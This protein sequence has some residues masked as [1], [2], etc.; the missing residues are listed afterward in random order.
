MPLTAE[1]AL[2]QGAMEVAEFVLALLALDRLVQEIN[3]YVNGEDTTASLEVENAG[4]GSL[5][6]NP[7][8]VVGGQKKRN[9][10]KRK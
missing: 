5:V 8:L 6:I 4:K 10:K 2:N 9:S 7:R 3:E 1:I